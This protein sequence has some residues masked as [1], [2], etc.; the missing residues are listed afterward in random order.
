MAES[1]D[2]TCRNEGLP[3]QN[4]ATCG[5]LIAT[6]LHDQRRGKLQME[7]KYLFH[8]VFLNTSKLDVAKLLLR[9]ANRHQHLQYMLHMQQWS[10][11]LLKVHQ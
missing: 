3:S 11:I 9:Y 1:G 5:G 4:R 6:A 8:R 7:F 2:M 10:H